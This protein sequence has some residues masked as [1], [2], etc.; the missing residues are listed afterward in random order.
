MAAFLCLALALSL[1][2]SWGGLP[3]VLLGSVSM[4]FSP[5]PQLDYVGLVLLDIYPTPVE[6]LWFPIVA[7]WD[8]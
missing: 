6:G 1:L 7:V 2:L 4:F 8:R 5:I 3:G